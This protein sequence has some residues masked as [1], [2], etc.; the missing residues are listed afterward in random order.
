VQALHASGRGE[1]EFVPYGAGGRRFSRDRSAALPTTASQ[2]QAALGA[3][4]GENSPQAQQLIAELRG[5]ETRVRAHE[6]AHKAVGGTVTGPISY[7]YTRGPDGKNYITGGEVS[8]SV[9]PGKTPEETVRRMEQVVRAALAPADPSPQD[10]AVA[11]RA[12]ALAQRAS[13]EE[14]TAVS[15]TTGGGKAGES[16]RGTREGSGAD[17]ARDDDRQMG[18]GITPGT[19]ESSSGQSGV[20]ADAIMGIAARLSRSAYDDPAVIPRRETSVRLPATAG[21]A[22]LRSGGLLPA[23][24]GQNSL[25][26]PGL[27]PSMITGFGALQPLSL[28]V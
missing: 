7:S 2:S 15:R 17:P 23:G 21:Q 18:Q 12:T 5:A 19:H 8:I 11:A 16:G 3:D 1:G 22:S 13:L 14:S 24:H 25:S 20:V 10:R 26:L 28:Y 6:A 27:I 9:S 4:E